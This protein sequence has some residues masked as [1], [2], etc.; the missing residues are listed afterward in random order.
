M[1]ELE[2]G[3]IK[4]IHM[5]P[6]E[7]FKKSYFIKYKN[8]FPSLTE[9]E[10]MKYYDE[11]IYSG[12]PNNKSGSMW[13]SEGKSIYVL[14]RILKP[15]KILEIGNFKGVSTNHILQAVEKNKFGDVTLVDIEERIDYEN[16]HNENF[17]RIIQDSLKFLEKENDFDLII[18]DGD[19]TYKHVKKEIE[20]I[21]KYNKNN[22]LHV[23]AHD[24]YMRKKV[25]QCEVWRA[26]DEMK[27]N[28]NQFEDF[29]DSV[30][31]CGFSIA[32]M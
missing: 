16:I 22:N 7:D 4:Y 13:E 29:L 10:F 21:L 20:L 32:K 24:Y 25:P 28:F 9:M 5:N 11:A 6:R 30:S 26:W 18:Q 14:I 8:L 31:D 1:Q 27:N 15:K 23:W 19:H 2:A 17:C 3:K 12:Y